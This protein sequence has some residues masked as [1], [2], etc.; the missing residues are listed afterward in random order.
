MIVVPPQQELERKNKKKEKR[1]DKKKERRR[2]RRKDQ[3]CSASDSS[4]PSQVEQQGA[5]EPLQRSATTSGDCCRGLDESA[6][7]VVKKRVSFREIPEEISSAH[8]DEDENGLDGGGALL[9]AGGHGF[10]ANPGYHVIT[11]SDFDFLA[12]GGED[13]CPRR[14]DIDLVREEVIASFQNSVAAAGGLSETDLNC[15]N[16]EISLLDS[17]NPD[18]DGV[19]GLIEELS[20]EILK[21]VKNGFPEDSGNFKEAP[22]S[23]DKVEAACDTEAVVEATETAVDTAPDANFA[24]ND[25]GSSPEEEDLDE[26]GSER[27][28]EIVLSRTEEE[29]EEESLKD[30]CSSG[31]STSR[32]KGYSEL[33]DQ[34]VAE[35]SEGEPGQ[36]AAADPAADPAAAEGA[37]EGTAAPKKKDQKPTEP[38]VTFRQFEV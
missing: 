13:A 8:A 28:A 26:G 25:S 1:A 3:K 24:P 15:R 7:T 21:P 35:M 16:N 22:K 4:I 37:E 38:P 6:A 19:P 14:N 31:R 33:I 11:N 27:C 29:E 9:T 5:E 23:L 30:T 36:V 10:A 12:V 32:S 2:R 18:V 20:V 34:I 17:G